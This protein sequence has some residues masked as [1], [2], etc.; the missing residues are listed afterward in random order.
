MSY[1]TD[2]TL[3]SFDAVAAR[4][5]VEVRVLWAGVETE[6]KT[7]GVT[8]PVDQYGAVTTDLQ[9]IDL[10]I[11][12]AIG[13]RV[14]YLEQRIPPGGVSNAQSIYALTTQSE[15]LE[16][17][18]GEIF[19]LLTADP[20]FTDVDSV[21]TR[22]VITVVR[23]RNDLR[24]TTDYG[25]DNGNVVSSTGLLLVQTQGEAEQSGP[26]AI[27]QAN[28][29]TATLTVPAWVYTVFPNFIDNLASD[30]AFKGDQ[31]YIEHAAIVINGT[32]TAVFSY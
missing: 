14:Q 21:C 31:Y 17:A 32:A 26:F 7:F 2:Y 28:D 30:P 6:T 5:T 4:L 29:N 25:L 24:L 13:R 22:S 1:T 27:T 12:T 3:I 10:L 20:D 23:S 19:V 9:V 15:A 8:L 16:L 18:P 11:R